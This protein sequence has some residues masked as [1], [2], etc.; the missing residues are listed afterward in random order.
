M[1]PF[2]ME[3]AAI[4]VHSFNRF[5]LCTKMA[6]V[7][8]AKLLLCCDII[9][10]CSID[11]YPSDTQHCACSQGMHPCTLMISRAK[12]PCG[13]KEVIVGSGAVFS[14]FSASSLIEFL[15]EKQKIMAYKLK[16]LF[17]AQVATGQR[18]LIQWHA[19]K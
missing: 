14:V 5:S 4:L 6:A 8:V 17:I 1:H 16:S 10:K 18:N 7:A 19:R 2:A 11:L 9:C 3:T 15:K 13:L 12:P